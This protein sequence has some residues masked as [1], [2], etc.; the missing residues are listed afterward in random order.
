MLG[1]HTSILNMILGITIIVMLSINVFIVFT[2]AKL[3]SSDPL[4]NL[5][6]VVVDPISTEDPHIVFKGH[7]DRHVS[8]TL[9]HFTVLL[10]NAQNSDTLML[11]EDH[12]AISPDPD[13]GPGHNIEI[14]FALHTPKALYAGKWKPQFTGSYICKKGIF[15]DHKTV[16]V[17]VADFNVHGDGNEEEIYKHLWRHY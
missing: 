16:V 9:Q 4:Q 15:T 5:R 17:K 12:L 13:T 3:T 2:Y 10:I 14:K 11:T 7:Y 1:K 6:G 8:C